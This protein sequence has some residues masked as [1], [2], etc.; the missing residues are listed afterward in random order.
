[1]YAAI[2]CL[3]LYFLFAR[4]CPIIDAL[5]E[6]DEL[7]VAVELPAGVLLSNIGKIKDFSTGLI[8]NTV[9]ALP[10]HPKHAHPAGRCPEAVTGAAMTTFYF[11]ASSLVH[12]E[13]LG[14]K[15]V[16]KSV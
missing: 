7:T 9:A 2:T 5:D 10:C 11:K 14:E 15:L 4:N 3:T 1:V 6:D 13:K 8:F 12:P 16:R